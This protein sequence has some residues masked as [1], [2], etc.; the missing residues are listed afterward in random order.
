MF[1]AGVPAHVI[2]NPVEVK[3]PIAGLV[4]TPNVPD[5]WV[6]V[7]WFGAARY[8]VGNVT[9]TTGPDEPLAPVMTKLKLCESPA[10]DALLDDPH[11]V[12]RA[13]EEVVNA[14]PVIEAVPNG[15]N[16][17]PIVPANVLPP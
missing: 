12:V 15:L 7:H 3:L 11:P 9:V 2:V 16:P 5:V 6:M 1:A 14:V 17:D 8:A 13:N 4:R 10:P